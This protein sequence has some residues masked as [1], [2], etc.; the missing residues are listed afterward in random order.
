MKISRYDLARS[1]M[2]DAA[3]ESKRKRKGEYLNS[4]DI[5]AGIEAFNKVYPMAD[6]IAVITG[7]K[8]EF[9]YINN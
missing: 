3:Q 6:Y 9:V 2:F 8:D 1:A 4:K 7:Q 5:Q